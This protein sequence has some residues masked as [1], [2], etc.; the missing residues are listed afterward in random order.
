MWARVLSGIFQILKRVRLDCA[1]VISGSVLYRD[2]SCTFHW[3]T[4]RPPNAVEFPASTS[5][6][7]VGNKTSKTYT[8]HTL[9]CVHTWTRTLLTSFGSSA[10]SDPARVD[11]VIGICTLVS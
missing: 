6:I 11:C 2:T 10:A 3:S 7:V 1:A 8:I 9:Y 5:R 4:K